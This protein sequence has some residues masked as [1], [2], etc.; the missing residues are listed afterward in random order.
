[1][2]VAF[3]TP[4]ALTVTPDGADGV[5]AFAATRPDHGPRP[6][7]AIA[8]TRP[9]TRI[10]SFTTTSRER[11]EGPC[12]AVRHALHDAVRLDHVRTWL[13]KDTVAGP[14]TGGPHTSRT[15]R[16]P[17]RIATAVGT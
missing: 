9:W 10:P 7:E 1:V 4:L 2:T 6:D 11:T 5:P 15:C 16:T 14:D 17:E 8:R 3:W 12:V 13:W